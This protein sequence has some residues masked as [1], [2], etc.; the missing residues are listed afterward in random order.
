MTGEEHIADPVGQPMHELAP[1][2]EVDSR[3]ISEPDPDGTALQ[4]HRERLALQQRALEVLQ[5][6]LDVLWT[7]NDAMAQRYGVT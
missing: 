2:P 4:V 5:F 1:E 3:C 7:M 6:K